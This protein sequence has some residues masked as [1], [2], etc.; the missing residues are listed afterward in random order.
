MH[1]NINGLITKSDEI[2]VHLE[3]LNNRNKNVDVICITE[4]NMIDTDWNTL[5][6][7]IFKLASCYSRKTRNGGSCILIKNTLQFKEIN[8]LQKYN[9]PNVLECSG[10]ELM[11]QINIVICIYR[12]P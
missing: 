3:E 9:I 1:Q 12:V 5:K 7:Y 2:M 4:H 8:N 6:I 11:E 10:V